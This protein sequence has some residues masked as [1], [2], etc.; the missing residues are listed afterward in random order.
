MSDVDSTAR[1]PIEA[2][3][4]QG[5]RA[6]ETGDLARAETAFRTVVERRPDRAEG[7][8]GLARVALH[9]GKPAE[10]LTFLPEAVR[11]DPASFDAYELFA[12]IGIHGG[13]ADTAVAWLEF[14]AQHLPREPRLFEYLV[15][16]YAT[17]NRADDLRQCLAH[18]G[19]LRGLP[20][21]QAALIFTRD[22]SMPE[23]LK[24]RIAIAVGF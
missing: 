6:L 13:V 4:A 19:R 7:H 2:F 18:Y 17:E 10:A 14:G 15:R 3:L 12:F 23:D 24:S 1:A 16:L 11:A 9:S 20:I 8:L 5:T 22:A 21:R